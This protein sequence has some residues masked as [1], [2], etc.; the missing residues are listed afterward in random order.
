MVHIHFSC[1]LAFLAGF[2]TVKQ[3]M[4]DELMSVIHCRTDAE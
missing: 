2:E 4:D 1:G 3:A